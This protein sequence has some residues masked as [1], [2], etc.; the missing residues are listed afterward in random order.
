MSKSLQKKQKQKQEEM[1][2]IAT[3]KLNR[4]GIPWVTVDTT[5]RIDSKIAELLEKNKSVN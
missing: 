1:E 4:Y 5:E 2:K 3:K